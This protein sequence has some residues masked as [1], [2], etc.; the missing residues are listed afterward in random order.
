MLDSLDEILGRYDTTEIQGT[1]VAEWLGDWTSGG[2][3]VES[4]AEGELGR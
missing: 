4:L 3:E 2:S 1:T